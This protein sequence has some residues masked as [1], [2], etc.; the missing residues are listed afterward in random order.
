MRSPTPCR[1]TTPGAQTTIASTQNNTGAVSA[2]SVLSGGAGAAS[3][4]NATA[5]G[6]VIQGYACGTCGGGVGA[7]VLQ[8]NG[9]RVTAVGRVLGPGGGAVTGASSAVGNSVTLQVKSS[10]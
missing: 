6:N 1:W 9:G 8:T 10:G 2:S 3:S 7:T 5:V 4:T